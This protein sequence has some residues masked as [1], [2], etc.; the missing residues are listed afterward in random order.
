VTDDVHFEPL[1]AFDT[2]EP[3]FIRG[4]EAGRIWAICRSDVDDVEEIV[5][6]ANA[7]MM[8]RIAEATDRAVS[9][10]PWGEN[11]VLVKF[12]PQHIDLES[13]A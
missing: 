11:H 4:F 13:S 9:A 5:G 8:I 12:G 6:N 1:I 2:D 3:Q 10:E 7:E